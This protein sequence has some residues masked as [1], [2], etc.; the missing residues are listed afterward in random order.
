MS[1]L[2]LQLHVS[3]ILLQAVLKDTATRCC[4]GRNSQMV[5]PLISISCDRVRICVGAGRLML[6][7]FI[8]M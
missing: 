6:K 4:G 7:L 5:V 2:L 3:S 8:Y 1:K